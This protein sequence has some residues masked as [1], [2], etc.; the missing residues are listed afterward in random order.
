M[1]F[2]MTVSRSIK[3]GVT[4]RGNHN[5]PRLLLPKM[6]HPFRRNRRTARDR[7]GERRWPTIQIRTSGGSE[8]RTRDGVIVVSL[9]DLIMHTMVSLNEGCLASEREAGSTL[10]M[11][12]V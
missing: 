9:I 4:Y 8:L 12:H 1:L 11:L 10:V 2:V 5:L 6:S 3:F 7:L